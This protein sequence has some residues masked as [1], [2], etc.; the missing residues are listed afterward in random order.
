MYTQEI[1]KKKKY[2]LVKISSSSSSTTSAH[3]QWARSAW[4]VESGFAVLTCRKLPLD[5]IPGLERHGSSL[6]V[7]DRAEVRLAFDDHVRHAILRQSAGRK[8]TGSMVLTLCVMGLR[9]AFF[10]SLARGSLSFSSAAACA[11]AAEDIELIVF[12][13]ERAHPMGA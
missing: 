11:V 12:N 8:A 4:L 1:I 3:T 2:F 10:V 5:H 13:N 9:D 7:H 6:L